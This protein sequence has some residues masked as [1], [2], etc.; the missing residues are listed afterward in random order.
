[1]SA[2]SDDLS[3]RF[4]DVK[5]L[6]VKK[7]DM[8]AVVSPQRDVIRGWDGHFV[9]KMEEWLAKVPVSKRKHK[10][11]NCGKKFEILLAFGT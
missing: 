3:V 2:V 1:M 6:V 7:A 10:T 11:A 4:A 5:A 8:A 9:R